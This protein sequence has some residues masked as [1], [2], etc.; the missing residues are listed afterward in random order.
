MISIIIP[1]HNE[2]QNLPILFHKLKDEI[3]KLKIEYEIIFVDD[4]STDLGKAQLEKTIEKDSKSKILV[5]RKN[6]GKGKALE[7]GFFESKGEII[8]F[9]D[10]DLQ[11]DPQDIPKFIHKIN[12]GYDLVN[13]YRKKRN[14]GVDKTFPSKIYNKLI[15]RLFNV[16]LHDINCGFKVMRREVLENV[17][18]YGDNYRILPILAKNEGFKITEVEVDHHA[19]QYGVSKYGFWRMLFGFFD[20]ISYFFLIKYVEKPLHFF[21]TVGVSIFALGSL[22]LIY[23]GIERIYF[24]ELL[25]RRPILFL[26]LLLV[27]VGVQIIVTGFIGELI[28]YLNK[29]QSR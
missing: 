27:I 8:V 22:I 17:R 11:D 10:A 21:G 14:D 15:A 20:L 5:L 13:G 3:N 1:F 23:L 19:R 12:E 24:Q 2:E 9:M 25:Y 6:Y 7:T 29:R 4:G 26:G 28:V 18:L 16:D